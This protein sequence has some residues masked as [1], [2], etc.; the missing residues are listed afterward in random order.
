MDFRFFRGILFSE[1]FRF[2]GI[3]SCGIL[4][5]LFAPTLD[6][7]TRHQVC[8]MTE[9]DFESCETEDEVTSVVDVMPR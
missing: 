5:R 2:H 9:A 8:Q 6:S 1:K 7:K 4:F 3:F